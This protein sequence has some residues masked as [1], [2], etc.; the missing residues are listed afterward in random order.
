M[1]M[2]PMNFSRC[3]TQKDI[4]SGAATS[5]DSRCPTAAR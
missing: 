5:R 3:L 4:E 1:N 2:P